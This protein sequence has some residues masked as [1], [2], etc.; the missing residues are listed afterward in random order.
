MYSIPPIQ[1]EIKKLIESIESKGHE[2]RLNCKDLK[3]RDKFK[4][5]VKD[6][7]IAFPENVSN[8]IILQWLEFY[9]EVIQRG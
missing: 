9:E 6:K 5:C 2:V 7:Y 8:T 1:D 3:K 4:F